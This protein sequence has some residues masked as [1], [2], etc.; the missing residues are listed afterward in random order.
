MQAEQQPKLP[1]VDGHL[2]LA[3]N[4]LLGQDPRLSL[5]ELR[6]SEVGQILAARKQTPTVTLPALKTGSVGV[7]FGTLFVLPVDAPS[8]LRGHG[9]T[10]ADEAHAAASQ[11]I[12]FY[13]QLESEGLIRLLGSR[14]ELQ[15]VVAADGQDAAKAPVG[16]VPLMEGADPIRSPAELGLWAE[17]G[18]RIVGPAWRKTRYSGGTGVPGPLTPEGRELMVELGAAELALDTSHMAEESFWQAL[19]LF[20]GPAIASHSNCRRIVPGDRQLSDEMIRAIVDRDGVVG[21]VVYN[22]FLDPHWE[23]GMSKEAV[24]LD[25]VA[26]HIEHICEL[27]RDTRH[28]GIGTDLDGGFGREGIPSELDSCADL[29]LIGRALVAAGWREDE[30][31]D[32]L[33]GNWLRWLEQALPAG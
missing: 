16:V 10:T 25:A 19:R 15:G 21:V 5:E 2:D 32:V 18:V 23:P 26:R 24:R 28:V 4:A 3:Y 1:V 9:Y 27:A 14:N 13:R 8:D 30:V 20:N 17:R 33:G 7:V 29:P 12:A 22:Q 31:A 6:E 11:Q